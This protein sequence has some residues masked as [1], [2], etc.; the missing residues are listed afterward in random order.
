MSFGTSGGNE[1]PA[2]VKR[3]DSEMIRAR[4]ERRSMAFTLMNGTVLEGIVRWFDEEAVCI[5][6]E[7]RDEITVF[8]HAIQSFQA[9]G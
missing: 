3:S 8:K 4:D 9:K 1:R 5:G 2:P 6:D 7:N